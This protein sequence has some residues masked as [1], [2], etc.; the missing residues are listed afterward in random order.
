MKRVSFSIIIPL[1]NKEATIRS[2][3]ESLTHLDYDDYEVV[4]IDDGSTDE[5]AKIVQ[6]FIDTHVKLFLK[7]NGGVSSARNYGVQKATNTWIIFLDADDF[8]LSTA[9]TEFKNLIIKYPHDSVFAGNYYTSKADKL[10]LHAVG[11]FVSEYPQKDTWH[12]NIYLRPGAFCCS[13]TAFVV[14]GGYDE[15]MS[16]NEDFEYAIRLC[17][18]YRIVYTGEPIMRYIVEES[19]ASLKV[20]K[21]EKDFCYYFAEYNMSDKYVKEMCYRRIIKE[22]G[23]R[24][25]AGDNDGAKILLSIC[26]E[27]FGSYYRYTSFLFTIS[28]FFKYRIGLIRNILKRK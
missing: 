24:K 5:S 23:R 28:V 13:K 6:S 9:L 27:K 21:L 3:L 17:S 26:A 20:H 19:T 2:T 4:V 11:C 7:P 14:S 10:T 8:L 25:Q 15:R 1:Y 18:R 16:Y 12:E 22:I